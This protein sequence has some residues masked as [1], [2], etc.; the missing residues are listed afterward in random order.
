MLQLQTIRRPVPRG[1][2]CACVCEMQS[3]E[4]DDWG[5]GSVPVEC[6]WDQIKSSISINWLITW[7]IYQIY[8][9]LIHVR[10]I[11]CKT[12]KTF[13]IPLSM[14]TCTIKLWPL[15]IVLKQDLRMS[16]NFYKRLFLFSCDLICSVVFSDSCLDSVQPPTTFFTVWAV[17]KCRTDGLVVV[18]FSSLHDLLNISEQVRLYSAVSSV[19]IYSIYAF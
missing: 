13:C 9:S 12:L 18:V 14:F 16:W 7:V 19:F 15:L 4:V 3:S 11:S 6:E 17:N 1:C 10:Q 5:R 2:G 8:W